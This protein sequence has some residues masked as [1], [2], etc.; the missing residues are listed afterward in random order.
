M[1][2]EAPDRADLMQLAAQLGY[3]RWPFR[4]VKNGLWSQTDGGRVAD[5]PVSAR[6]AVGPR[7]SR[8]RY[9]LRHS[10]RIVLL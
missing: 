1:L 9:Q 10:T 8:T 2:A 3:V 7:V 4:P 6:P 5:C